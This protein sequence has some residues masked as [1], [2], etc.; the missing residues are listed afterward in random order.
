MLRYGNPTRS[1][2]LRRD[3]GWEHEQ[4]SRAQTL[5]A[6][7]HAVCDDIA[8]HGAEQVA[9]LVSNT[10]AEDLADRIRDQL[11]DGGW[12]GGPALTGPGW[13]RGNLDTGLGTGS[14]CMPA[15]ARRA[16]GWSTAV[17]PSC[18]PTGSSSH[19]PLA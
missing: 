16:P 17:P 19:S 4:A 6:M 14:C 7:A 2:Q 12:L 5:Q 18:S 9:A 1:Q 11:A 10:D 3:Q 8:C 13:G 15:A